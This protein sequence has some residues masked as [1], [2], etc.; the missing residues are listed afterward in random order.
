MS[1]LRTNR[2]LTGRELDADALGGGIVNWLEG[3]MGSPLNN[4]G[5]RWHGGFVLFSLN[6]NNS[7]LISIASD[8]ILA[9]FYGV[10]FASNVLDGAQGFRVVPMAIHPV[11]IMS[12]L[13]VYSPTFSFGTDSVAFIAVRKTSL[14]TGPSEILLTLQAASVSQHLVCVGLIVSTPFAPW[15]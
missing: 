5:A 15:T 4:R 12:F 11:S 14:S 3:S 10:T 1:Y 8:S 13:A 2:R 9:Q 7:G 6:D